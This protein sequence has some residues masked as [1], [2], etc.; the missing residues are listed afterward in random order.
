MPRMSPGLDAGEPVAGGG[1]EVAL[2]LRALQREAEEADVRGRDL[3]APAG[4]EHDLADARG[5]EAQQRDVEART[6]EGDGAERVEVDVLV[7]VHGEAGDR[8]ARLLQ[9]EAHVRSAISI[10]SSAGRPSMTRP[11]SI[12]SSQSS[13]TLT[14][15]CSG[16][17]VGR[18][19]LSTVTA[20]NGGRPWTFCPGVLGRTSATGLEPLGCGVRGR[21]REVLLRPLRRC[22]H[23]GGGERLRCGR[24]RLWRAELRPRRGA[25]RG[26]R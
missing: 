3:E 19:S 22:L 15:R 14:L 5:F 18:G 10:S 26:C 16:V 2:V 24:L 12:A 1:L 4:G 23:G 25:R 8:A 17:R 7:A 20:L 21:R 6:G 11:N 13:V 9:D